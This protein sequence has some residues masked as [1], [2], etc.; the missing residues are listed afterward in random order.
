MALKF[1]RG[2]FEAPLLFGEICSVKSWSDDSAVS[3]LWLLIELVKNDANCKA[4]IKTSSLFSHALSILTKNQSAKVILMVKKLKSLLDQSEEVY[5][6]ID[7]NNSEIEL[8]S[9]NDLLKDEP[10]WRHSNDKDDFRKIDCLP[11]LD[12][13]TNSEEPYLPQTEHVF[14][15]SISNQKAIESYLD[16]CFRLLREDM[17]YPVREEIEYL[18]DESI[19]GKVATA[20]RN[21]SL[22]ITSFHSLSGTR[23]S[24]DAV[25]GFEPKAAFARRIKSAKRQSDVGKILQTQ[26]LLVFVK[27]KAI[28]GLGQVTER[29][30]DLSAA[31]DH[32]VAVMLLSE[33]NQNLIELLVQNQSPIIGSQAY[34]LSA[35]FFSYLPILAR[36]KKQLKIPLSEEIL[37]LP[38]Q[39]EYT[40]D[41]HPTTRMH[42]LSGSIQRR[43]IS[44][45]RFE[46]CI[47]KL[48]IADSR[49]D[50]A[51]LLNLRRPLFLDDSQIKAI[52]QCLSNRV[53]L[54]QGPPG[55]GKSYCGAILAKIITDL[56]NETI[57]CICYTNHALDQF[58]EDLLKFQ[59]D[60]QSI[61][62]IGG[63]E[64]V[65]A[66][67]KSMLLWDQVK[68]IRTEEL[69]RE[70]K[71]LCFLLHKSKRI[72]KLLSDVIKE[73]TKPRD[74]SLFENLLTE[75]ERRQFHIPRAS[76][77]WK[78][79]DNKGRPLKKDYLWDRWFLGQDR[80]ALEEHFRN[81]RRQYRQNLWDLE[82]SGRRLMINNWQETLI[83]NASNEFNK[84]MELFR[85][86]SE[87]L[88][89][90]NDRESIAV[91][92]R[93]RIIGCTTTG[94][95]KYANLL[96]T[97][98]A[99][100][101][102]MEEAGE[103]L[104]P[105]VI[106]SK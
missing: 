16:W 96:D 57:L 12:E 41:V 58:L 83:R 66:G 78:V 63:S 74:Y 48:K 105:H 33:N 2:I 65:S 76:D 42:L 87:K 24:L 35:S 52:T 53:G 56:T 71:R 27:N 6:S 100:V 88:Q 93:K 19:S 21:R 22:T 18:M 37:S 31:Q 97:V 54:I 77:D 68:K 10:G 59:V 91:L 44:L 69:D 23:N 81:S 36:L 98:R 60:S 49:T 55:T 34:Q 39:P 70:A 38:K 64:K 51:P 43:D 17:M 13:L 25:F 84:E 72:I 102:I 104:E 85:T 32:T 92:S 30:L 79:V 62:R 73:Q 7:N 20:V 90:M 29:H 8:A 11:H 80:G 9:I 95:A 14:K 86:S 75:E 3:I 45:R 28:V 40:V 106:T 82:Y 103:I 15:K 47:Q 67:M 50:L 89:Q 26:S 4:K 94:A 1:L 101:I 46:N 99:G 61:V 5:K